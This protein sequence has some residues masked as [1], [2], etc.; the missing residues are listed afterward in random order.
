MG[1]KSDGTATFFREFKE[2]KQLIEVPKG[3]IIEVDN[4]EFETIKRG[5]IKKKKNYCKIKMRCRIDGVDGNIRSGIWF[6][7]VNKIKGIGKIIS[8]TCFVGGSNS[9]EIK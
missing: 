1:T 6:N 5:R 9:G 3:T 7:L 2:K 4:I 8:D